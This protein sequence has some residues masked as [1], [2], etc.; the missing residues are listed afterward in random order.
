MA[1]R[2][3]S[4]AG[5]VYAPAGEVNILTGQ[6]GDRTTAMRLVDAADGSPVMTLTVAIEGSNLA[7]N[8]ILVKDWS[9]NEGAADWLTDNLVAIDTG[10]RV[11]SGYVMARVMKLREAA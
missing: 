2:T 3:Y 11:A 9:E 8:E 5:L 4:T 7:A 1:K 10:R 6:Y